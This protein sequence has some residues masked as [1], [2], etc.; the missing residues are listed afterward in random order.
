MCVRGQAILPLN[1][2]SNLR[3]TRS[4]YN[5]F[6]AHLL[7]NCSTTGERKRINLKSKNQHMIWINSKNNRMF[8]VNQIVVF[9]E[10]LHFIHIDETATKDNRD[11]V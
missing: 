1:Y 5:I 8:K 11:N 2:I 6:V 4:K 10:W 3:D 9:N 7:C